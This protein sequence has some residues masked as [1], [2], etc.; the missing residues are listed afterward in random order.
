MRRHLLHL[1]TAVIGTERNILHV[2]YSG[3]YRG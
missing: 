2:R 3:R 1:L